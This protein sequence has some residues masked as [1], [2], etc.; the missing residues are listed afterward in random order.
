VAGQLLG[1]RD[2][3]DEP[4]RGG[5]LRDL[6]GHAVPVSEELGQVRREVGAQ[7]EAALVVL[8]GDEGEAA[9]GGTSTAD[10]PGVDGAVVRRV[11]GGGAE[12]VE[13]DGKVEEGLGVELGE[14]TVG[15]PRECSEL[16]PFDTVDHRLAAVVRDEC[17]EQLA[18]RDGVRFLAISST[19]WT[20]PR[21]AMKNI[22]LLV[23]TGTVRARVNF[24]ADFFTRIFSRSSGSGRR[25]S[26]L[27]I[28]AARAKVFPTRVFCRSG[29]GVRSL[30]VVTKRANSMR[31]IFLR[32]RCQ[33]G[34]GGM[35]SLSVVTKR[36][37]CMRVVRLRARSQS[38]G[39]SVESVRENTRRADRPRNFIKA[40]A[41]VFRKV[42]RL[43]GFGRPSL[44]RVT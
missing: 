14:G 34:G 10:D 2:A 36:V 32:A 18:G 38:S 33:S 20:T 21:S 28:R 9:A 7:L 4:A 40:I 3:R 15:R 27:A 8:A 26:A 43:G 30:S 12:E 37:F 16:L 6:K 17:H 22:T 13:L 1:T 35:S 25:Q 29:G 44:S 39:G 23:V 41:C 19:A 42:I 11:Q 24:R 31:A 5:A